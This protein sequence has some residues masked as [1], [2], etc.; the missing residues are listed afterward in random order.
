MPNG[1]KVLA[2]WGLLFAALSLVIPYTSDN[3]EKVTITSMLTTTL[4][5]LIAVDMLIVICRVR[6]ARL[7]LLGEMAIYCAF[8][9]ILIV[10]LVGGNVISALTSPALSNSGSA[11]LFV[12]F[13][14]MYA[15]L[16]SA[17]A[18]VFIDAI[19][20]YSARK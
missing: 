7:Y 11:R 19:R 16:L 14:S 13:G 17:V 2:R 9:I 12:I 5:A 18:I 4:T 10:R 3:C 6:R 15:A 8:A 20:N 1:I